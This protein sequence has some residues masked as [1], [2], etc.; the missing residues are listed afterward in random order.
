MTTMYA[1]QT[2]TEEDKFALSELAQAYA[3]YSQQAGRFWPLPCTVAR[4]IKDILIR[5]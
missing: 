2:S 3:D 1:M 5:G 4:R